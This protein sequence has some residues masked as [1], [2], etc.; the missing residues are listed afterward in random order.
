[1]SEAKPGGS[2]TARSPD[3]AE[4]IIARAVAR[5]WLLILTALG[6]FPCGRAV[7]ERVVALTQ[8]TPL[9]RVILGCASR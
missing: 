2:V 8:G 4:F 5:S 1:M 6:R 7:D 9:L 3:F